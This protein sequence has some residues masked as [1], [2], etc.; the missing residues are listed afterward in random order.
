MIFC[1]RE[2]FLNSTKS[3]TNC[4]HALSLLCWCEKC[5]FRCPVVTT[6]VTECAV[7]LSDSSDIRM[8]FTDLRGPDKTGGE[9]CDGD[10]NALKPYLWLRQPCETH[11]LL[12]CPT[13]L[14][15]VDTLRAAPILRLT[16]Y[17]APNADVR[18]NKTALFHNVSTNAARVSPNHAGMCRGRALA[19]HHPHVG[20][21]PKAPFVDRRSF[22]HPTWSRLQ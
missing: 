10:L 17:A 12:P 5:N 22:R 9:A 4:Y 11:R 19:R 1:P 18:P 3:G 7:G 21:A 6:A 8:D 16:A 13:T 14:Q 15:K 20:R 2:G